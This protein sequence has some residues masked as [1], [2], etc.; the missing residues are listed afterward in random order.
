MCLGPKPLSLTVICD[1]FLFYFFPQTC[2]C[3]F[4]SVFLFF[5][6]LSL[7]NYYILYTPLGQ[8]PYVLFI[9]LKAVSND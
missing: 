5:S 2:V 4:Y 7:Y 1:Y 3:P 9:T 8:Q 6:V